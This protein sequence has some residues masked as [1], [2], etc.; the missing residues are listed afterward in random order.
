MLDALFKYSFL[1]NAVVAGVL[2]SIICGLIGVII[3]EKR[4]LMMTGGI[5]HTAYGGVGL[6][7]LLGFEPVLGAGI[8]AVA[9]AIGI[10]KVRKKGGAY[11]DVIISLLWA[12]G[13]ALGIAFVGL[14]PGYPPDMNSYLF[15]NILSV[16]KADIYMML[17]LTLAVAFVIIALFNDWKAFLF[18]SRFAEVSGIRTVFL[19]YL[20]LV[21]VAL[22]VVALIRVA[23]IILVIALLTA[24]S[25]CSALITKS[26]KARMAVAVAFSVTF[27]L[28]GLVVSFYLGI[29]SGATIVFVAVVTYALMLAAKS[30]ISK[31]RGI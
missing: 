23:G 5:A 14:M 30:L 17:P 22:S 1:Q 24:P 25:A 20:L 2:A 8:F 16:T 11:T 13:M 6:G 7:Y 12:F 27:C 26:L 18:D 9:A 31:K 4:L 21:L 3:V 19:E 10:G 28:V 29:A 15:G